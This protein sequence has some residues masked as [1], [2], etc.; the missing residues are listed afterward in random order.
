LKTKQNKIINKTPKCSLILDG[1]KQIGAML[2]TL[3]L[4][5]FSKPLVQ[6]IRGPVDRLENV[7]IQVIQH[8]VAASQ[9]TS[10]RKYA[11]L[12]ASSSERVTASEDDQPPEVSWI[13]GLSLLKWD[14]FG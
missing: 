2:Q 9:S 7:W 12:N 5:I 3:Y 11:A 8:W 13:L 1:A 14:S 6:V 4:W 10:L